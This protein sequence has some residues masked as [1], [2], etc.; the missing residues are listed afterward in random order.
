MRR[1]AHSVPAYILVAAASTAEPQSLLVPNEFVAGEPAV[2]AEVNANF[3]EV[4]RFVNQNRDAIDALSTL[5]DLTTI[6]D[7]SW[8]HEG[9]L[10]LSELES[11]GLVVGFSK[12]VQASDL[13]DGFGG[14]DFV[15]ELLRFEFGD[16]QRVG[17]LRLDPVLDYSVSNGRIDDYLVDTSSPAVTGAFVLFPPAGYA[18]SGLHKIVIRGNFIS[19]EDGRAVDGE[20]INADLPSGDIAQ[21]GR[22][23]SWFDVTP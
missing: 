16:W 10:T 14:E 15:V 23:E 3:D 4:E 1:T 19:D 9:S 18:S 7:L 13:L 20:F 22:F 8:L 2:A 12:Q 5:R 6:E 11:F 17:N 21:G